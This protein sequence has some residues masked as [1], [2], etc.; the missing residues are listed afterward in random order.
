MDHSLCALII[1]GLELL[2]TRESPFSSHV[3]NE[4]LNKYAHVVCISEITRHI[5]MNCLHGFL[6][7]VEKSLLYMHFLK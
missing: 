7:T 2:D 1:L 3:S 5:Q 4:L 6:D